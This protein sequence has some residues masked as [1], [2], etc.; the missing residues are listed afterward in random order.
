M[1]KAACIAVSCL[2]LIAC[3]H[4]T[5]SDEPRLVATE[6]TETVVTEVNVNVTP[7]MLVGRWGE[8]GDCTRD[9]LI[10]ADGT[11]LTYTGSSGTWTLD[12]NILTRASSGTT[13]QVW[14]GT[15]GTDQL[16]LGQRNGSADVSRRCP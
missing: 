10:N 15:I 1:I 9:L 11:F 4:Q 2:A 14:V 16:V 8:N 6:V 12:G 7:E 5:A 3:R 13:S